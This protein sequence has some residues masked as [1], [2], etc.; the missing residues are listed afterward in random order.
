MSLVG[1]SDSDDDSEQTG[2][3]RGDGSKQGVAVAATSKR[4][5]SGRDEQPAQRAVRPAPSLPANFHSLYATQARASTSDDPSLHSGR[6]RQIPHLVG[7]WPSFVYLEWL[8]SE[9]DL[10]GLDQVIEQASKQ[11]R[12]VSNS[13]IASVGL[14]SSL[15]SELGVRLPLHISLSSPLTL[16]TDNKDAFQQELIEAI[17]N[18]RTQAF[19]SKIFGVRWVSNFDETRH[20]LI[21]SLT[22]PEDDQFQTLLSTCNA[23]A[24][25][26]G[27]SELYANKE[28]HGVG[29]Q[30]QCGARVEEENVTVSPEADEQF[31]ISIAWTLVKP[32]SNACILDRELRQ[33]LTDINI[34]VEDVLIKI[35]N[36]VSTVHLGEMRDTTSVLAPSKSSNGTELFT[37]KKP[38][39]L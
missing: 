23:V 37:M 2:G 9:E 16:T 6:Q 29:V 21:M 10:V 20:F 13:S 11:M 28:N 36:I 35:G 31:H 22:K 12:T 39:V 5:R 30:K 14:Q 19:K 15:R 17:H 3:K 33:K 25:S 38:A 34:P 24:R 32:T 26:F 18:A 4:K 1:Y 27:L 8:P 7:N